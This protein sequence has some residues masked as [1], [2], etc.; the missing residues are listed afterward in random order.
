MFNVF[1][2]NVRGFGEKG[3]GFFVCSV[4]FNNLWKELVLFMCKN[5]VLII[6]NIVVKSSDKYEYVAEYRTQL[7]YLYCFLKV[8]ICEFGSG[9]FGEYFYLCI[10]E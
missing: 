1:A 4:S 3:W 5:G 6:F 7:Y 10:M 9:G 8:K 2:E